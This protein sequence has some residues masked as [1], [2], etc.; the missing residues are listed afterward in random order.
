MSEPKVVEIRTYGDDDEKL[1][2]SVLDNGCVRFNTLLGGAAAAVS[3]V[4]LEQ[5]V[6]LARAAFDARN[7]AEEELLS[8]SHLGP[9]GA[10]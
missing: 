10:K 1:V 4:V 6:A 2:A 9:T 5:L 3:V 7:V 8:A